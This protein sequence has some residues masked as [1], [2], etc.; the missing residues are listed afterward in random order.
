M[1]A[2]PPPPAR[3]ALSPSTTPTPGATPPRWARWKAVEE[4]QLP[5]APPTR[6]TPSPWCPNPAPAGLPAGRVRGF[7][8]PLCG[9][10]R[11]LSE[12]VRVAR[13]CVGGGGLLMLGQG[14]EVAGGRDARGG[15]VMMQR[16][17]LA[18]EWCCGQQGTVPPSP[19]PVGVSLRARPQVAKDCGTKPGTACCPSVYRT[20]TSPQLADNQGFP[21]GV[22]T[23][24]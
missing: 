17:W 3:T 14:G 6:A 15:G 10:D 20:A 5:F 9:S 4:R 24:A 8:G 2:R 22:P 13:V 16:C 1:P 11:L 23:S 21:C 19:H 12:G 7:P 18:G